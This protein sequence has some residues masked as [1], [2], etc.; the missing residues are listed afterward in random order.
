MVF[1]RY[2]T[3]HARA[4]IVLGTLGLLICARNIPLACTQGSAFAQATIDPLIQDIARSWQKRQ[5]FIRTAI[6]KAEGLGVLPAGWCS[7]MQGD[8]TLPPA[9]PRDFAYKINMTLYIDFERNRVRNEVVTCLCGD[10]EQQHDAEPYLLREVYVWDGANFVRYLPP[11][12]NPALRPTDPHVYVHYPPTILLLTQQEFAFYAVGVL[13]TRKGTPTARALRILPDPA[14]YRVVG[15]VKYQ[16]RECVVLRSE[17]F[18]GNWYDVW[19]D[20]SRDAAILRQTWFV[21]GKERPLW[22]AEAEYGPHAGTWV[23]TQFRLTKYREETRLDTIECALNVPLDPDLFRVRVE[24]GTRIQ[25]G[26]LDSIFVTQ[27]AGDV[28][29]LQPGQGRSGG[30]A[31]MR[32]RYLLYVTLAVV[33][34]LIIRVLVAVARARRR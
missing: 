23:P 18:R 3:R 28:L 31:S 17:V 29:Q 26:A 24:A 10:V 15:T 20:P 21:E 32:A 33:G 1:P 19:V 9:P 25:S 5:K 6:W 13:P 14:M 27:R 11:Q 8:N 2:P 7:S 30:E 12:S 4:P 16:G 34:A 22:S